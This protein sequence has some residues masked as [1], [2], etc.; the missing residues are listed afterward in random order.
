MKRVD[1]RA[2][3][4]PAAFTVLFLMLVEATGASVL[5]WPALASL[6]ATIVAFVLANRRD[7]YDLRLLEE[8]AERDELAHIDPDALID[9]FDSVYCPRCQQIYS[10]DFKICPRCGDGCR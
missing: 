4:I 8:V 5:L 6:G 10:R 1:K 7:K 3:L 2:V 9:D